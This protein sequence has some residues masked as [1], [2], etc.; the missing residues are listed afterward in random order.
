MHTYIHGHKSMSVLSIVGP[1]CTLA[2]SHMLPPGDW[3]L[4]GTTVT[5]DHRR[6]D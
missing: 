1:K 5:E 3:W 6:V 2:A 4:H